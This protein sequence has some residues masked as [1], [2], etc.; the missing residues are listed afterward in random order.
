LRRRLIAARRRLH[1][2]LLRA[3]HLLWRRLQFIVLL[4]QAAKA[5]HGGKHI[6]LLRCECVAELLQPSQIA[7]QGR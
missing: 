1:G 7:V 2:Y 4:C 5:L 3:H 6:R